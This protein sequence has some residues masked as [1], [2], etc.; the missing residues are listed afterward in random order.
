MI[1]SRGGGR[2]SVQPLGCRGRR[3]GVTW[4][5]IAHPNSRGQSDWSRLM[6]LIVTSCPVLTQGS[7]MG[8]PVKYPC[9]GHIWV[10]NQGEQWRTSPHL[11]P[12]TLARDRFRK[13]A[14]TGVIRL[15]DRTLDGSCPRLP[16]H[17]LSARSAFCTLLGAADFGEVGLALARHCLRKLTSW[18]RSQVMRYAVT[19]GEIISENMD[20][21]VYPCVER[22]VGPPA[23]ASGSPA[24]A[25][26][27]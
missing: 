17:T 22:Q 1:R 25:S 13:D 6:L 19:W 21:S 8:E 9:Y 5:S 27:S 3:R 2:Y 15:H 14:S 10:P 11:S 24:R 20:C 4:S 12:P 26:E 23:R 18:K 7:K 16:L